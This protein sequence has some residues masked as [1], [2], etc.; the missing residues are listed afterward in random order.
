MTTP[1]SE[2]KSPKRA[3]PP[4]EIL[5]NVV[6][7][8]YGCVDDLRSGI[9]INTTCNAA[10]A[11]VQSLLATHDRPVRMHLSLHDSGISQCNRHIKSCYKSTVSNTRAFLVIPKDEFLYHLTISSITFPVSYL[12]ED[13]KAMR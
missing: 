8:L 2:I 4:I 12:T 1:S 3:L 9:D 11:H 5:I 7:A 10:L 13:Q 6:G